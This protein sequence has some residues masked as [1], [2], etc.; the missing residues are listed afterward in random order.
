M[1]QPK[2][3]SEQQAGYDP[4]PTHPEPL[5]PEHT[6]VNPEEEPGIDEWP[7]DEGVDIDPE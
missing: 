5:S 1:T 6:T 3:P 7:D 4:I 2:Y